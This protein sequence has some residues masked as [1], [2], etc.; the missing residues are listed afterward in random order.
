MWETLRGQ[1]SCKWEEEGGAWRMSLFCRKSPLSDHP[2]EQ[3]QKLLFPAMFL[4]LIPQNKTKG[5]TQF[6]PISLPTKLTLLTPAHKEILV[7]LIKTS[8]VWELYKG[9]TSCSSLSLSWLPSWSICS[10]HQ[11]GWWAELAQCVWQP[12]GMPWMVLPK[13]WPVRIHPPG[14]MTDVLRKP[15]C[16][17]KEFRCA[18]KI[19][20]SHRRNKTWTNLH[21]VPIP[22]E[23]N[24]NL[25]L[26]V[27]LP[28]WNYCNT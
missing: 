5:E 15:M 27:L 11:Q 20:R 4:P 17:R 19:H 3:W 6:H 14:G 25:F 24:K 23:E 10:K 16:T 28:S 21:L 7:R 12:Q 22:S 8:I 2:L 9:I 18:K 1:K 26:S 13:L